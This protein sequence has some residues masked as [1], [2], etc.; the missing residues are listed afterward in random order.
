MKREKE[1]TYSFMAQTIDRHRPHSD[2]SAAV[3][4]AFGRRQTQAASNHLHEQAQAVESKRDHVLLLMMAWGINIKFCG[5]P[6]RAG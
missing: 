3:A 5:Q 2:S 6:R 4:V 1:G